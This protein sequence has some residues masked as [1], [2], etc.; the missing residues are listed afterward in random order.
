MGIKSS[1]KGAKFELKVAKILMEAWGVQLERTPQSGGWG[2][3]GTKGDLAADP[4]THP[5]YPFLIEVKNQQAWSLHHL[6]TGQGQVNK[7]W[8]KCKVQSSMEKRI[9]LLIFTSNLNPIYA[10]FDRNDKLFSF[11]FD[12]L[13][14]RSRLLLED[15]SAV[16]ALDDLLQVC[17]KSRFQALYQEWL[18]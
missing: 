8:V 10:R 13:R 6:F 11:S 9:A 12:G 7:W 5:K 1:R 17:P 16:I 2:R 4:R 15:G 14:T 18:K 3:Y